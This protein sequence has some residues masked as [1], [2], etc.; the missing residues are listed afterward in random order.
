MDK[1]FV[2]KKAEPSTEE[3][4]F[5]Y[6]RVDKLSDEEIL[7]EMQDEPFHLRSPGFIKRRRKEFTAAKTLIKAKGTAKEEA[8]K[9]PLII[10]A[11]KKHFED[12]CEYIQEWQKELGFRTDP[13]E[14][15][16][17]IFLPQ[18]RD[19]KDVSYYEKIGISWK[20]VNAKIHVSFLIE[21]SALFQCL[22]LHLA[23]EELWKNYTKLKQI[24]A[25]TIEVV[26]RG[27]ESQSYY[28][29]AADP[30]HAIRK[31]LELAVARRVFPGKCPACPGSLNASNGM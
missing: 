31:E 8:I 4:E 20:T 28:K 24:I 26:S 15:W 14:S 30:I 6:A 9:D 21:F 22:K 13:A 27:E 10:E 19:I 3:L 23:N 18:H 11:K 12:L 5:I 1:K 7:D 2:G 29:D 25:D 16:M 17:Q